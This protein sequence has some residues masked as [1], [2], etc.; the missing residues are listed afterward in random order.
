MHSLSRALEYLVHRN[1]SEYSST[2]EYSA[3]G[4]EAT[5]TE[6]DLL[7]APLSCFSLLWMSIIGH[8]D[9]VFSDFIFFK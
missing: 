4:L 1:Y 2:P 5:R 3:S 8:F 7:S 6:L 9:N